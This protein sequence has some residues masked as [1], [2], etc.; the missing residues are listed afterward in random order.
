[1]S[2]PHAIETHPPNCGWVGWCSRWQR[3]QW[4]R[5]AGAVA[6]PDVHVLQNLDLHL[7]AGGRQA[8]GQQQQAPAEPAHAVWAAACRQRA[9]AGLPVNA[10]H[11]PRAVYITRVRGREAAQGESERRSCRPPMQP[12]STSGRARA[13]YIH[14]INKGDLPAAFAMCAT[15]STI[16]PLGGG[17]GVRPAPTKLR[18]VAATHAGHSRRRRGH[19]QPAAGARA[20]WASHG[21]VGCARAHGVYILKYRSRHAWEHCMGVTESA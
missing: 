14:C 6:V 17:P 21:P 3:R 20:R 2:R 13:R 4:L 12:A 16:A 10:P 15:A 18:A 1:M 11:T 7:R 9:R 8:G 19:L 5:R